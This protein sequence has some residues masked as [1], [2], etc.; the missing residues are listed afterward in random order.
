M[1][2]LKTL[3]LLMCIAIALSVGSV[4]ATS[5]STLPEKVKLVGVAEPSSLAPLVR[6]RPLLIIVTSHATSEIMIETPAQLAER[7]MALHGEQVL[8]VAA[9]ANAPWL[10]K[11]LFIGSGLQD[12]IDERNA[13]LRD[14]VPD[15]ERSPVVV[16]FEGEMAAALKVSDLGKMGYAAFIIQDGDDITRILEGRVENDSES[17]ITAASGLIA[18]AV[19]DRLKEKQ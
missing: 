14:S 18:G 4:S 15:I 17:E 9:V 7:G 19:M 1:N 8:S 12:L 13:R 5:L 6:Q 2:A 3:L 11:K 10:V 16:D